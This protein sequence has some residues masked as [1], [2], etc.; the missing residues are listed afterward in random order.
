MTFYEL[1]ETTDDR[2]ENFFKCT[3]NWI[4]KDVQDSNTQEWETVARC[5]FGNSD[6]IFYLLKKADIALLSDFYVKG[7]GKLKF[8]YDTQF[9]LY[10]VELIEKA[11]IDIM[12]T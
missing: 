4:W 1:F 5:Y 9:D 8:A 3:N 6:N 7:I 10:Y 2:I 11:D 12:L